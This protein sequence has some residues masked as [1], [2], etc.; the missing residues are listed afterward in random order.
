[1]ER[2][3]NREEK[4]GMSAIIEGSAAHGIPALAK[5]WCAGWR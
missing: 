2:R 3:A 5:D 1:M 4:A